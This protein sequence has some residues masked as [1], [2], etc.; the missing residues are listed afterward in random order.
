MLVVETGARTQFGEIA[1]RVGAVDEETEFE[2]G[3][4]KFGVMLA[5]VMIVI[6]LTVLTINQL[7]G[8]P[9]IESLLFAVALA[10]G[11]SPELLP[12]II[13]V[14]LANGARHLVAAVLSCGGSTRSRISAVWT[15]CAPTR[16]AP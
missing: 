7:M 16:P 13:S 10:V 11:L 5:R 6:V 8:R 12:A 2:R 14:T 1:A 15:Y 4:R 9:I 3:I